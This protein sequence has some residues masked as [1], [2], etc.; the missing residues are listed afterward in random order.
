MGQLNHVQPVKFIETKKTTPNDQ[1]LYANQISK[2]NFI[3]RTTG[4][5]QEPENNWP[6]KEQNIFFKPTLIY[7]KQLASHDPKEHNKAGKDV[8]K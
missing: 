6:W 5:M 3:T 7:Q 2:T 1:Q 4:N 8:R